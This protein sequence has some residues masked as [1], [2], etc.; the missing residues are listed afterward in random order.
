MTTAILT[1]LM[2]LAAF[3]ATWFRSVQLRDAG[4]ID[5]YWAPGFFLVA[6]LTMCLDDAFTAPQLLLAGMVA[7]W[8]ARL[9]WHMARRHA[10]AGRE[11]PRYARMRAERGE[12]FA[13]WSLPNIFL[14]QAAILWLV[15]TPVHA[16]LIAGG[17]PLAGI[18]FWLVAGA[19]VTLFAGGL[20]LE[21]AADAALTRFRADPA[22]RG[23]LL[24]TGLFA[25]VR[26]PNHLGE[27]VLW[28]GLGLFALAVSG[29]WWALAGPVLL[30]VL[31]ARLSGPPMLGPVLSGRDGYADWV[32]KTPALWP[33]GRRG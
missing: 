1:L 23:R 11:D 3:A 7:L 20:A 18:M 25:R 6:A 22:N 8:S 12:A 5:L 10:R 27:I 16:G 17:A 4:V 31:I 33:F 15:A 29:R 21:T 19:G 32:A 13:R 9:G 30:A 24:V 2:T 14:L 26:H 28:L